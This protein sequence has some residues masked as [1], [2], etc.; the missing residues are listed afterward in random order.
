MLILI[1]S[2][3][4]RSKENPLVYLFYAMAW[5]MMIIKNAYSNAI[6]YLSIDLNHA[7]VFKNYLFYK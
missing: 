2:D 7:A 6:F 5:H 1:S 3:F 4:K